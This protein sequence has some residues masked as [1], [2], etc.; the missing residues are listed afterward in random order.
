[1]KVIMIR[2][3]LKMGDY[4]VVRKK[5]G[6]RK[7]PSRYSKLMDSVPSSGCNRVY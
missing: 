3:L 5:T 7:I 2:V 1:M 6:V 4:C